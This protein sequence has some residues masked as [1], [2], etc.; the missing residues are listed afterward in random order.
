MN[1][2]DVELANDLAAKRIQLLRL[3][4]Q[5]GVTAACHEHGSNRSSYYRLRRH[6]E[7]YPEEQ[8]PERLEQWP[9]KRRGHAQQT[10]P[11]Q[12]K[13]IRDV[14]L[15]HPG[16]G[17]MRIADA[18]NAKRRKTDR[19]SHSTVQKIMTEEGLGRAED[20][21]RV[22]DVPGVA[23][24]RDQRAFVEKQNPAHRDSDVGSKYPGRHLFFDSVELQHVIPGIRSVWLLAV[25][26]SKSSYAIAT[27]SSKANAPSWSLLMREQVVQRLKARLDQNLNVLLLIRKGAIQLG[28]GM[29][30]SW[31]TNH[32]MRPEMSAKR[33]GTIDRFVDSVRRDFRHSQWCSLPFEELKPANAA[34]SAWLEAYNGQPIAGYPNYG[35]SPKVVAQDF[36]PTKKRKV[37][38]GG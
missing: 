33:R 15:R 21:L 32:G 13:A 25:V 22:I 36:A 29:V 3:A 7:G 35:R 10:T 31:I 30:V 5:I 9:P 12:R 24:S 6:V 26:D 1:I 19:R 34:F 38:P 11:E 2:G 16:W 18:F 14:A 8:W 17:C 23:L 4:K 20:R 37:P 28:A 27:L